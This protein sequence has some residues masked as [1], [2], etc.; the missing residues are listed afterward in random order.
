MFV[1]RYVAFPLYRLL[2]NNLLSGRVLWI[3]TCRF[4][5]MVNLLSFLVS[6]DS[7]T[8][9]YHCSKSTLPVFS[10]TRSRL[11]EHTHY[12]TSLCIL[13]FC[14]FFYTLCLSIFQSM[15]H[16]TLLPEIWRPYLSNGLH[17][18]TSHKRA[19]SKIRAIW[20]PN[21]VQCLQSY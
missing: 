9:S 14:Q 15:R 4:Y 20:T 18:A 21:F 12:I 5:N 8:Y 7:G 11:S 3:F 10:C 1:N 16:H 17:G 13:F 19:I 6:S 2:C